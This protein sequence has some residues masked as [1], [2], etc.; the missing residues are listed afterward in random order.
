MSNK[1]SLKI[2]DDISNSIKESSNA[3]QA[4]QAAL[5][6]IEKQIPN[7]P[8][9]EGDGYAPDGSFVWD[10]WICPNCDKRYEVDYEEYD[11]CPN[12]GQAI[13]WSA[14]EEENV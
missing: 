6:A 9:F 12:C 4:L 13:D 2:L 10:E 3:G 8:T 5:V 1:E 11:F 14:D 7:K